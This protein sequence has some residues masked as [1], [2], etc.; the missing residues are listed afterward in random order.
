LT[1]KKRKKVSIKKIN[2]TTQ[3]VFSLMSRGYNREIVKGGFVN[4][5]T[6]RVL[7]GTIYPHGSLELDT[8]IRD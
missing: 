7:A 3:E 5:E 4:G 2:N 8:Q 1:K 6:N